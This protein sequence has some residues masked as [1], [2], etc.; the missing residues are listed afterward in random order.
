MHSN[1][2]NPIEFVEAG[3]ISAAVGFKDLRTGDTICSEGHQIT[4]ESME[5]PDPVIG[6]A[7]EPKTQQDL[8][9]LGIALGKL[10]EE[11]PTFSVKADQET[12]QTIISGMGELHLDIII[13]RLR[14]E[15]GVEINQGAPHVNYKEAITGTCQHREVFRKQTGGRGKFADIIVEIGP[16]DEGVSGLQFDNEVKGGNIPKEFIPCVQKGFEMAMANGV[17]AGYEMQSMKVRLLD[18]SF[19]PVDSDALSFELAARMAFR[20]ACPKA[21]PVLLEPIMSLEVVTPE[22]YM[23]DIVGDLNRRR[24]QIANMDST[25]TGARIIKAFVPLA[26]QFGYVTV[27]RTLSSGRATSTMSFDHY[28][29][30]PPTLAKSIVERSGYRFI[31]NNGD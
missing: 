7:V 27:L 24:G 22:E 18:G 30:V 2:Q 26:E 17:L 19:H 12:G 23:G 21:N 10:A 29:E 15:F 4:L 6:I 3:D 9:K 1:H 28:A 5:F 13:D 8:D 25:S 31:E 16:A 14:R 11:D 20:N